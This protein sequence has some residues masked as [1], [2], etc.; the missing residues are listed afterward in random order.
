MCLI[1]GCFNWLKYVWPMVA[2]DSLDKS[3]I[4]TRSI[5]C[6]ID[7]AGMKCHSHV[8]TSW[9]LGLHGHTTKPGFYIYLLTPYAYWWY[10]STFPKCHLVFSCHSNGLGWRGWEQLT[11]SWYVSILCFLTKSC[12]TCNGESVLARKSLPMQWPSWWPLVLRK[13]CTPQGWGFSGLVYILNI[14]GML[15]LSAEV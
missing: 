15:F 1:C 10:S 8:S 13:D 6:Y 14:K 12:A 3:R 7:Q 4:D 2:T 5:Y 9:V 11:D